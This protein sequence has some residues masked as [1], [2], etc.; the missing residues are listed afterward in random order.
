MHEVFRVLKVA[1]YRFIVSISKLIQN[2]AG[3][4]LAF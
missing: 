1:I 2:Y 3:I 4:F